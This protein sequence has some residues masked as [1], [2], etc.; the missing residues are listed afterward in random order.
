[1]EDR[2]DVPRLYLSWRSP[3]LFARG[4][5]ELDLV[6]DVL[7]NGKTSRLYRRLVHDRRIA[8]ELAA[9][10]MSRELVGTFQIVASAA[11]GHSLDELEAAI[12]EE[13]D[14]FAGEGP[15]ADELE[16]GRA[17]AEAAFVFRLQSLGG[18]GG[19]ADQLNAYNVYR[20]EPDGFAWDLSR[21]VGATAA[22]LRAAVADTLA[23]ERAIA[24]SVVPM[25]RRD[26][27]A[28]DAEP[29]TVGADR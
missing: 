14:R 18:F 19:K 29:I 27:A 10:Q 2:V 22:D 28:G 24:L 21:Y 12:L 15:T 6:S 17:Q 7:G 25:G 3:P 26:H 13:L 8:V 5:A 9:G 16:R 20:G 11:P 4:D 1:M 23:P